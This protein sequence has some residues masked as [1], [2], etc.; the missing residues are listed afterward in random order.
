MVSP[1]ISDRS[2]ITDHVPVCDMT[3]LVRHV[4]EDSWYIVTCQCLVV[5]VCVSAW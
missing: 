2:A 4:Y 5:Y 3:V 1:S